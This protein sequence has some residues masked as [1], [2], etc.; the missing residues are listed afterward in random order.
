MF[1]GWGSKRLLR[2]QAFYEVN[3]VGHPHARQSVL[4]NASYHKKYENN[5][6]YGYEGWNQNGI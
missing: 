6:L 1:Y 5:I 3:G 4:L 2:C